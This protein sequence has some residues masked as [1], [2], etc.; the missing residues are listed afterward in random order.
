[1]NSESPSL[2]GRRQLSSCKFHPMQ[3]LAPWSGASRRL[4]PVS[5][6][7]N[8][9]HPPSSDR[10][11]I[12][13]FL[14]HL[15]TLLTCGQKDD[16][17]AKR[18]IAV[19]GGVALVDSPTLAYDELRALIVT[20]NPYGPSKSSGFEFRVKEIRKSQGTFK[21]VE[22]ERVRLLTSLLCNSN[23]LKG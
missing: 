14:R 13:A 15:A 20:Q 2:P 21:E 16:P 18:V 10:S 9:R 6:N 1:M 17:D 4:H 8:T 19:T 22:P 11:H 23:L 7:M 12:P 5:K 3:N